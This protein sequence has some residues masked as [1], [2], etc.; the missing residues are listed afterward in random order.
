MRRKPPR[1]SNRLRLSPFAY[2]EWFCSFL[3]ISYLSHSEFRDVLLTSMGLSSL[4]PLSRRTVW[5][6][7][8]AA[9]CS[10]FAHG[11]LRP[12]RLS[13]AF[14]HAERQQLSQFRTDARNALRARPLS[15]ASDPAT[16]D[17]LPVEWWARYRCPPPAP[18]TPGATVLVCPNPTETPKRGAFIALAGDT[19]VRVSLD[20][21]DTVVSDLDVMLIGEL[22]PPPSPLLL[23]PLPSLASPAGYI[24]SPPREV[25]KKK[26]ELELDV[27]QLAIAVR[28]LDRKQD[29][30]NEMVTI[31]DSVERSAHPPSEAERDRYKAIREE[32][33]RIASELAMPGVA[34]GL[35]VAPSEQLQAPTLAAERSLP[36]LTRPGVITPSP[37][38]GVAKTRRRTPLPSTPG[39]VQPLPALRPEHL[40]KNVDFRNARGAALLAKALTR[41]ALAKLPPD[42]KL[43]TAPT[44]VRADVMECMS[45]CV[46]V[47]V[48]ARATRDFRCIEEVVEDVRVRFP[49]NQE[50]LEAIHAA[51]RTFEISSSESS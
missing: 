10:A 17:T 35:Q 48:R 22:D 18:P 19:A 27:A 5:T 49:G 24:L 42:A 36:L 23:S 20:G 43:K 28:L 31:N 41:A 37:R 29:L 16:G 25:D 26:V 3:D 47:L 11:F 33:G 34:P 1:P 15:H 9:M 13:P 39:Q 14:L 46:A 50:A 45:A 7:A 38:G 44:K 32:L 8:R 2:H 30:V 21:E 4:L 6:R 51:A 12:R 40:A